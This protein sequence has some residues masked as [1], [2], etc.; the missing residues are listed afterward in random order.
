M[1]GAGGQAGGSGGPAGGVPGQMDDVE[2]D[3]RGEQNVTRETYRRQADILHK[4]LDA[5]R[6][7]YQ[8][9]REDRQRKAEAPKPYKPP[10]SPPALRQTLT[11]KPPPAMLNAPQAGPAAGVRGPDEEVLRGPQPRQPLKG[12]RMHR[13]GQFWQSVHSGRG[14]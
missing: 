14:R 1:L 5:Q 12:T 2:K 8:K 9:D 7:L 10:S 3:L 4:M 11:Q 6:S 13:R